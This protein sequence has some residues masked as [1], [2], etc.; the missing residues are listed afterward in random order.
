MVELFALGPVAGSAMI[1]TVI[2]Y[3][4]TMYAAM[5]IDPA[6]V[7]NPDDLAKDV[8]SAFSDLLSLA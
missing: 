8:D 4:G 7:E 3:A 1:V 6:A 2:S 5:T